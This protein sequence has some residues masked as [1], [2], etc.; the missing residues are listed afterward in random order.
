ML[1]KLLCLH[2]SEEDSD[3]DDFELDLPQNVETCLQMNLVYQEVLKEKLSELERLL[4]ENQQQQVNNKHLG[5]SSLKPSLHETLLH[6]YNY[7]ITILKLTVS[8]QKEVEAQL[9]GPSTSTSSVLGLPPQK[10]FLGYFMKPYFKDKL[11]GLVCHETNTGNLYIF[12]V[13][14]KH[15]FQSQIVIFIHFFLFAS[16]ALQQ[17]QKLKRG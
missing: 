12:V 8:P 16:R 1:I 9:S 3:D 17:I 2:Q 13:S 14:V 7:T 5:C 15:A 10:L 11:T 6:Q 4:K